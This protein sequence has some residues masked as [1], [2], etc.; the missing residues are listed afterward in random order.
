MILFGMEAESR[1]LSP[2]LCDEFSENGVVVLR[3]FVDAATV[4]SLR[5]ALQHAVDHP[6]PLAQDFAKTQAGAF[7]SDMFL[8]AMFPEF[9][10]FLFQSGFG[11]VAARLLQ[12][13]TIFLFNDEAL[14]K[15]PGAARETPWHHDLPYWPLSGK[16]VCS[17][18]L[19]LDSTG[20]RNGGMEFL[21][22]SHRRSQRFHPRNFDT[23]EDRVTSLDEISVKNAQI[24]PADILS[25]DVEPGDVIA[26]HALTL[27]RAFGNTHPT[28]ARRA[29]VYRLIGGDVLYDPRPRT[30][31]LIWA[32]DLI[33]GQPFHSSELFPQ[34]I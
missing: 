22:G 34:L 28:L 19:A 33:P 13:K 10:K 20:A 23:G 26:F 12:A 14:T 5:A 32:P 31:P 30:I 27:H 16:D 3:K 25:F 4:D 15:A 17:L 11:E 21:R 1:G 9:R 7:H 29:L 6:T 18:W 8:S 2:A 24:D